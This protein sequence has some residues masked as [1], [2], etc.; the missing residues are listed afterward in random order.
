MRHVSCFIAML[1]FCCAALAQPA[2]RPSTQPSGAY[3][4]AQ[5]QT[6]NDRVAD[7][8]GLNVDWGVVLGQIVEDGPAERA[9]LQQDDVIQKVNGRTVRALP[10][11]QEVLR[12]AKPGQE[13]TV[14]VVRGEVI[15]DIKVTLGTRPAPPTTRG[16]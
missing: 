15:K 3:M 4:G 1:L 5:L 14:T 11:F 9:G 8:R 16:R 10:E 2:T 6:V 12:A 13:I 7:A